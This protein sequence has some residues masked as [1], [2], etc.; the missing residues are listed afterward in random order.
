M[1]KKTCKKRKSKRRRYDAI[2]QERRG[3]KGRRTRKRKEKIWLEEK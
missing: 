1:E 3:V 2:D